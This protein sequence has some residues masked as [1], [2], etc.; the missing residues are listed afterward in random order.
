MTAYDDDGDGDGGGACGMAMAG[1][2]VLFK[3]EVDG[4]WEEWLLLGW[5]I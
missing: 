5:G 4:E 1:W 2:L 3:V